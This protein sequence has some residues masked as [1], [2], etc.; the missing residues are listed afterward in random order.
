MDR[1]AEGLGF[2]LDWRLAC[3]RKCNAS[4]PGNSSF[5]C[6]RPYALASNLI[7]PMG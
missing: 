5:T 3:S 4:R 1:L 6:W 2:T 7:V